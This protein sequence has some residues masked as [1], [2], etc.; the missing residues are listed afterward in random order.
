M[1]RQFIPWRE[2]TDKPSVDDLRG[3]TPWTVFYVDNAGRMVAVALGTSGQ[4]LTSTGASSAPT[5]QN[6]GVDAQ[7]GASGAGADVVNPATKLNFDSTY[8]NVT[9]P[10]SGEAFI[11]LISA[12][13]IGFILNHATITVAASVPEQ[14]VSFAGITVAASVS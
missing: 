5:F 1:S 4:V 11:T 14:L 13:L 6:G 10:G 7:K 12:I 9:A 8:F 2:I 3:K